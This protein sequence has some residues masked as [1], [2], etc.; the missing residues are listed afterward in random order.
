MKFPFKKI[1]QKK[2][3]EFVLSKAHNPNQHYLSTVYGILI[4]AFGGDFSL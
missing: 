2:F 4:T 3:N 1:K